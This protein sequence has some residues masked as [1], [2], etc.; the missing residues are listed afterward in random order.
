[1]VGVM[2]EV[3]E[4][5]VRAVGGIAALS[6]LALAVFRM[7]RA[8]RLPAARQE[9]HARWLLRPA[10][11]LA[12]TAAFVGA[13]VVLWRPLPLEVGSGIRAV[14]LACARLVRCSHPPPGSACACKPPADS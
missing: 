4:R 12:A 8:V 13:G 2:L 3:A 14:S 9:T 11:L 5:S 10:R 6:V 7:L 1:M